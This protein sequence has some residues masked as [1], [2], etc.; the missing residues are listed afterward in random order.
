MLRKPR[1]SHPATEELYAYWNKRR[2]QRIAPE[3]GEI[4]PGE[5]R[6]ILPD[7]FILEVEDPLRYSWRLAGTRVCAIHCRELRGRDFLGD[8]S[9]KDRATMTAL[10]DAVVQEAAVGVIQF[11]GH[12]DR[13]QSV[14]FE[15]TLMPL[16]TRGRGTTRILGGLGSMDVPYWL[17]IMPPVTRSITSVRMV[18]PS[19]TGAQQLA[20]SGVTS[21]IPSMDPADSLIAPLAQTRRYGHLMVVDG[22]KAS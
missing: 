10:L 12:T 9:G 17:G 11:E 6:N 19:S 3:R 4:E 14:E 13:R 16:S 1:F 8:W 7:T 2:G 15:L 21:V 18:W 5:I 20:P 22:G